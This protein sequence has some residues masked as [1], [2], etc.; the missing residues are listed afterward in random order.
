M[1]RSFFWLRLCR[2]MSPHLHVTCPSPIPMGQGGHRPGE[3][4]N[5]ARFLLAYLAQLWKPYAVGSYR[6]TR[7]LSKSASKEATVNGSS[8]AAAAR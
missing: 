8:L 5:F 7:S 3:G 6:A 2:A 1:R 4:K